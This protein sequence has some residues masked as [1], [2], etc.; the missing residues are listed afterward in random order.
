MNV[1]F[2]VLVSV[3]ATSLVMKGSGW[4]EES[5]ITIA[6]EY[7]V[8]SVANVAGS[9]IFD[10]LFIVSIGVIIASGSVINLSVNKPLLL[11]LL[12]FT[13]LTTYFVAGD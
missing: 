7:N 11:I 13:I 6:K 12:F 9:N 2:W 1:L 4:L 8:P 10:L 5:S 3:L